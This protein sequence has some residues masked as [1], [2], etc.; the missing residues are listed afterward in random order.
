MNE[1][2]LARN[3]AKRYQ[4]NHTEIII[5]PD[6]LNILPEL[7]E[8]FG[9]P[10]ADSS[11]IPTYYIAQEMKK[12]FK[13]ALSGDGGDELFGGYYDYRLAFLT[14]NYFSKHWP[15]PPPARRNARAE[16]G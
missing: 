8:N 7:I 6:I 15:H 11:N 9:E 1:I 2:P 3:L 16:R 12:N 10:F 14:D 13:V 5:K 4:T